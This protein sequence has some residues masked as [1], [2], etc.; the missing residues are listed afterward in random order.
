M[1]FNW[2]L[3]FNRWL[4]ILCFSRQ[5][6]HSQ[7][8]VNHVCIV[9]IAINVMSSSSRGIP[10]S[11]KSVSSLCTQPQPPLSRIITRTVEKLLHVESIPRRTTSLKVYI[12]LKFPWRKSVATTK[13]FIH[14]MFTSCQP[15]S[16]VES[17]L[18]LLLVILPPPRD[19]ASV[20]EEAAGMRVLWGGVGILR[21]KDHH[22][23]LFLLRFSHFLASCSPSA[24]RQSVHHQQCSCLHRKTIQVMLRLPPVH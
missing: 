11:V 15:F 13:I 22:F 8:P 23:L 19:W 24:S 20:L 16:V 9:Q 5:C 12:K 1:W 4:T 3:V 14:L 17:G 7:W 2:C 10:W 18:S 21:R 6:L